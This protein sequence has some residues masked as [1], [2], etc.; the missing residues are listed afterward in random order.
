MFSRRPAGM[1]HAMARFLQ[2]GS[3]ARCLARSGGEGGAG[4]RAWLAVLTGFAAFALLVGSGVAYADPPHDHA[5]HGHFARGHGPHGDHFG[6]PH[7]HA[8]GPARGAHWAARGPRDAGRAGRVGRGDWRMGWRGDPRGGWHG[9]HRDGR[10]GHWRDGGWNG[11]HW[12]A[13]W[14]GDDWDH[15]HWRGALWLGGDWE[16]QY[17]P[18]V[19]YGWG[20]PWFMASVPFGAMTI[21]FGGV[22]YYYLN[23]VYYAWSPY[24]D[25]YVVT[26]PPPVAD[27]SGGAAAAAPPPPDSAASGQ[28]VLGLQVTPLKGQSAQQSANDRYACDRWAVAQSGF[29]PVDGQ[30]DAHASPQARADYRRA[31]TACLHARGYRVR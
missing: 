25:G 17:W 5:F 21:T 30:Q 18:P 6:G 20:Y 29:N 31:F 22:P 8:G 24:Y 10:H 3:P 7:W 12:H 11:E 27:A 1:P 28:G 2:L 19:N 16:G 9:D 4:H 15:R 14:G 23:H 26:D 13:G